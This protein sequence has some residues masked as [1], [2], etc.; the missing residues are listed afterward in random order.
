MTSPRGERKRSF[1][2]VACPSKER[3]LGR[4][5]NTAA[6]DLITPFSCRSGSNALDPKRKA[7]VHLVRG[8]LEVNGQRL[9]GGDAAVLDGETSLT[10]DKGQDAELLVFDLAH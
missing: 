8:Q 1:V 7:Y 2:E 10:L 9:A 6:F 3:S 4:T 5:G